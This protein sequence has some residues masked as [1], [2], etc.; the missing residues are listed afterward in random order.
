M[1]A[2]SGRR[3]WQGWK[4]PWRSEGVDHRCARPLSVAT[5]VLVAMCARALH[6]NGGYARTE[7][8]CLHSRSRMMQ[9]EA[10]GFAR[11]RGLFENVPTLEAT[12]IN[13]RRSVP[14]KPFPALA[15]AAVRFMAIFER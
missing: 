14:A 4:P 1:A 13:S 3:C 7:P 2:C 5:A 12:A 15:H 9:A 8:R 11:R 10:R 6:G